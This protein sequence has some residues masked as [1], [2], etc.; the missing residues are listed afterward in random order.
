MVIDVGVAER[1]A[2]DGI[3]AD[4]DGGDGSDGV[5]YFVEGGFVDGGVKVADVERGIDEVG[6]AARAGCVGRGCGGVGEVI[7]VR[8]R[9]GGV[10]RD[11]GLSGGR[12]WFSSFSR[13][14]GR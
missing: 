11:G 2:G 7:V 10:G 4:A 6:G 12:G 9:G 13:H 8:G 5:E 1:A 3:A 14:D